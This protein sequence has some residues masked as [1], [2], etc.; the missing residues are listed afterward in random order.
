VTIPTSREMSDP[1]P[2]SPTH[3]R[4][5][6]LAELHEMGWSASDAAETGLST[7][8]MLN[9]VMIGASVDMSDYYS[10]IGDAADHAAD[11]QVP[12]RPPLHV[13]AFSVTAEKPI[14]ITPGTVARSG[15]P[16]VVI[17]RHETLQLIGCAAEV[18]TAGPVEQVVA[19]TISAVAATVEQF[20]VVTS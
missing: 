20:H 18:D 8:V 7:T 4:D 19:A 6:I 2:S 11:H 13:F 17:R 15:S 3:L 5:A 12:T 14:A 9:E 10:A 16:T 1:S